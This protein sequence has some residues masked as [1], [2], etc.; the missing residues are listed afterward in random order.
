[1]MKVLRK[2]TGALWL[3]SGLFTA[4]LTGTLLFRMVL[5]GD[6]S[7]FGKVNEFLP[8]KIAAILFIAFGCGLEM[9]RLGWEQC[10]TGLKEP[11]F[12]WRRR[13]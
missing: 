10:S 1:M 13:K 11:A 9:L 7:G 5:F 6:A 12:A 8:L 4:A 3:L 2:I